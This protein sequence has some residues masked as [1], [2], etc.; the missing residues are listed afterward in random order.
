MENLKFIEP[1]DGAMVSDIVG[2]V[3]KGSLYMDCRFTYEPSKR[4]SVNRL[5]A[6][7]VSKGNYE[8]QI[9]LDGYRNTFEVCDMD[10]GKSTLLRVYWL[11][12]AMGKYRLS[13]DDNI[14]CLQDIAKNQH[15]YS[16]IF[17]N[18][19]LKIYKDAHDMYG[20]KIHMNIYYDC[21]EHGGF[22][23][24]QMPD[25][26]RDEWRANSDWFTLAFHA[27]R[28]LPDRIYQNVDY[29]TMKNDY[30]MVA[31]QIIRFA[32]EEAFSNRVTTL[33]WAVCTREGIRAMRAQ[34]IEAIGASCKIES[35]GT[36]DLSIHLSP[37]EARNA[38]IYTGYKD[39]TE[40]LIVFT[41]DIY[42]NS[43]TPKRIYEVLDENHLKYPLRGFVD[44]LIH[45]QYFYPDYANYLPDYRQRV[46]AGVKWC[47]EHG[48]KP[49]LMREFLFD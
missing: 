22:D 34:G 28:N 48:L 33:H 39:F 9:R 24:T 11:R 42:L 2:R 37:E 3:E 6:R 45:E 31:E 49:S 26:Y 30:Q 43:H 21:P 41:H 27:S 47:H 4:V 17:E 32:G 1:F 38:H 35:D 16:S 19:F 36:V 29:E 8:V 44:L 25:K 46:F 13:L 7:E 18:P 23:L 15:I 14:W 10:S 12:K 40:D 5:D 20:T